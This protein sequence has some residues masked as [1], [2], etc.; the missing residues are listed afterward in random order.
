M[1]R[2]IGI[3]ETV[4]SDTV[5]SVSRRLLTAA[6]VVV[7][8]ALLTL[9][10]GIDRVVPQTSVTSIAVL[11]AVASLAVVGLL[12]YAAPKVA[13]LV[14]MALHGPRRVVENIASAA[15]WLVVLGGVLVAHRGLAGVVVPLL[16]GRAWLHDTGFLLLAVPV[17]AVVGTRLYASLGPGSRLLAETVT[18]NE[19]SA[20]AQSEAERS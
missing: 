3:R 18:A 7:V 11:G 8:L 16:G 5:Q 2:N 1:V 13:A 19:S 6:W 9:V 4:D 20:D 15:Y 17:V 10:P 14:R 12:L